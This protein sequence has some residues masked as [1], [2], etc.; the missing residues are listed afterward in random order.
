VASPGKQHKSFHR[1]LAEAREAKGARQAGDRQQATR[2]L[3]DDYAQEWLDG[4]AGRTSRRFSEQARSDYRRSIE[5]YVIQFFN[6]WR[7]VG[8]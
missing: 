7:L 5:T 1:T 2:K 6:G 3:L 8:R 4:Y